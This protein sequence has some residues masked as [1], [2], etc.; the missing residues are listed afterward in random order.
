MASTKFNASFGNRGNQ[1][2]TPGAK[3]KG[4]VVARFNQEQE[5]GIRMLSR[6]LVDFVIDMKEL[7]IVPQSHGLVMQDE[8]LKQFFELGDKVNAH[9]AFIEYRKSKYDG[10]KTKV[11]E[12]LVDSNI[13]IIQTKEGK[14]TA[15][16]EFLRLLIDITNL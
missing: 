12:H 4:N 3:N 9:Y 2:P 6:K 1:N 7:G 14:D 10:I 13:P 5:D 8:R 15:D 16:L 11:I